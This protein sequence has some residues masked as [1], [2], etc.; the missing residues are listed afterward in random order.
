MASSSSTSSPLFT[1]TFCWRASR[2]PAR[3]VCGGVVC[4]G[5]ECVSLGWCFWHRACYGCLLCGSRR[6]AAG[7]A[8]DDLYRHQYR[9]QHRHRHRGRDEDDRGG[10]GRRDSY[11]YREIDEIP[12]CA[13]CLAG[14]E[15]RDG[16]EDPAAA[17]ARTALRRV[18]RSDGGGGALARTR[19][20]RMREGVVGGSIRAPAA[21]TRVPPA[22]EPPWQ[23]SPIRQ[24]QQPPQPPLRPAKSSIYRQP[25]SRAPAHAAARQATADG[26]AGSPSEPVADPGMVAEPPPG[27]AAIYVSIHDPFGEPAFRPSPAKPI[28]RWM[29]MLCRHHRR[30]HPRRREPRPRSVLDN[31]FRPPSPTFSVVDAA[32]AIPGPGFRPPP[33]RPPAAP[34][35][36]AAVLAS[37]T[38]PTPS[39][40]VLLLPRLRRRKSHE[41]MLSRYS[42]HDLTPAAG[43][44]AAATTTTTATTTAYTRNSN[45]NKNNNTGGTARGM[46]FVSEEPARRPTSRL[47]R[48]HPPLSSSS[49]SSSSA[50]PVAA[51]TPDA[52]DHNHDHNHGWRPRNWNAAAGPASPAAYVE[53]AIEH[54]RS[55]PFHQHQHRPQHL[56]QHQHAEVPRGTGHVGRRGSPPPPSILLADQVGEHLRRALGGARR[57]GGRTPPAQSREFLSRYGTAAG[58]QGGGGGGGSGGG[59]GGGVTV[60]GRLRRVKRQE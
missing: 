9:D 50:T 32:A 38:P 58:G 51:A 25:A 24:Q 8:V 22:I 53:S 29:Q 28:P 20:E 59:G 47:A 33:P 10:G 46:S 52:H 2:C 55:S 6:V 37:P 17:V 3:A 40:I 34:H 60:T 31:H 56:P 1:C 23:G 14:C 16:E 43:T 36:Q 5:D 42:D 44:P 4:R 57:R 35:P 21:I 18:E 19:W 41:S 54:E 48:E 27:P 39:A 26:A 11:P 7:P 49:S 13:G 45:G 15:A 30:P 12:L